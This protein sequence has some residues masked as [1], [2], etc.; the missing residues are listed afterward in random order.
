MKTTKTSASTL[1][2]V[3]KDLVL[4]LATAIVFLLSTV[5]GAAA[6]SRRQPPVKTTAVQLRIGGAPSDKIICFEMRLS[7]VIAMA[8][9]GTKTALVSNPINVEIVHLA[10][11]S[12]PVAVTYLSQGQYTQVAIEATAARITYLDVQ[13]NLLVTNQ[14][15]TSYH[16]TVHL[17]PLLT[18]DASP[19]VF[20]LQVNPDVA[21]APRMANT[22]SRNIDQVFRIDATRVNTSG[23]QKPENGRV[24][25][26]VGSVTNVS[27]RSLL[28]RD[29]QTGALLTFT[30]DNNTRYY[31]ASFSTL[32]GLI[33][34]VHGRSNKD[35]SLLARDIE[36]LESN[37]GAVMEGVAGGYIPGSKSVTLASQDG[38]GAGMK[39]SI[40]GSGISIDPSNNPNFVVDAHDVD[41]TGLGSLQFDL[42]SLVVGQHLQVQSMRAIQH[43]S[44]GNAALVVPETVRL[45]PQALTGTVTNY[46][47]GTTPGTFTFDLAF[48]TDA[49]WHVLNPFFYTMH[50]YVQPGTGL[51]N[52]PAGISDG[53]TVRVWGLVFY[54][55]LPE[56]G[57]VTHSVKTAPGGAVP[58]IAAPQDGPVFIMVAGRISGNQ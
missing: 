5:S 25:R 44:D 28:L 21:N 35:G 40:V 43:D 29:G 17:K 30:V 48:A 6:A 56:A 1:Q 58:M 49:S 31:N 33:V 23:P 38:S 26:I 45:E 9:D 12:E 7:S 16:A 15:A 54:S 37:S 24:N 46:Q 8:A 32:P 55:H 22:A 19:V 10:G 42:D 41:M 50:V 13:T 47:A 3:T 57:S 2:V 11:D 39:S 34:A 52:L 36:A 14:L 51:Q 20:N 53:S 4:T 18:L 27:G